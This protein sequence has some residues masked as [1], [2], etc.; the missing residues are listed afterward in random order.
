MIA[1][2]KSSRRPFVGGPSADEGRQPSQAVAR[3]VKTA[4]IGASGYVGRHL[5]AAYRSTDPDC[6]GTVFS[7]SQAELSHFDIRQPDLPAL[8]LEES[9]HEAVL[10]AS[11]KPNIGY[12]DREQEASYAV[13]VRGMLELI[14]QVAKTRMQVVFLSSDYVFEGCAGRNDDDTPTSPTTEYGRQKA[15]VE[16]ELPSITDNYLILRLSKIYGI[17]RGDGTLLDEIASCLAAGRAVRAAR[18]QVFCPTYVEDLTRA[19]VS[20]QARGL[21]GTL[22]VC[23]SECWSRHAVALRMAEAMRVNPE[24]VRSISLHELPGMGNRPLNT[25]MTCSRLKSEVGATFT[26]LE[27]SIQQVAAHGRCEPS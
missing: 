20:I 2:D 4:V 18:D 23:N 12:C 14:R 5:W 13:N 22:N 24:L 27:S 15:I 11:A 26:P 7:Q 9:G 3:T 8:R 19:I 25:S 17:E 6:V 16:R 10:I 21:N 1:S